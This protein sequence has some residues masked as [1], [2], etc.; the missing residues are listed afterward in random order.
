MFSPIAPIQSDSRSQTAI[1]LLLARVDAI[2]TVL[3]VL[4]QQAC[5]STVNAVPTLATR[6]TLSELDSATIDRMVVEMDAISA[7]LQA[8]HAALESAR[9]RGHSAF[10]ATALLTLESAEAF[11]SLLAL[12][13]EGRCV[14]Q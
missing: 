5:R 4:N 10:A 11:A 8:G 1:E 2:S 12:P 13:I 3:A 14:D 7:A 9:K 6:A